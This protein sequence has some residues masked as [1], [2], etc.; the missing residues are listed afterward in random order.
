MQMFADIF[1]KTIIKTNIDQ[2]AASLGAAAIAAK[3]VGAIE[4]YHMILRLHEREMECRPREEK[5]EIY[6]KLQKVFVH[7]SEVLADLGD[8][9][10]ENCR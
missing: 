3:A 4:D 5:V 7:I 9:M 6:K 2:D 10:K 1:N 8:F